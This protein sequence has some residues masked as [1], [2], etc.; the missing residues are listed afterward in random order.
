M[1]GI[2]AKWSRS[3]E[4]QT[5]AH[6]ESTAKVIENDP[7]AGISS[8]IH[9]CECESVAEGRKI[10][11]RAKEAERRSSR[12]VVLLEMERKKSVKKVAAAKVDARRTGV[13]A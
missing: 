3:K 11:R 10:G 5:Y 9:G 12:C 2:D 6:A 7:R 8:V 1:P 13:S 4:E